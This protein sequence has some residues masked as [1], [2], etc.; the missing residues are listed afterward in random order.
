M[1]KLIAITAIVTAI[2]ISFSFIN[3]DPTF[4]NLKVLPKST[5]H[6]QM[7]SIMK[8]FAKALGVKCNFCHAPGPDGKKLDFA[9]DANKHKGIARYMMKMTNKINKKYFDHGS[10]PSVT[11]FS[12][13]NGKKEPSLFPPADKDE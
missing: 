2:I 10:A 13:H 3:E 8:H 12:C 6:D 5:T 4:K 9:S 11:C 1:K 7:D